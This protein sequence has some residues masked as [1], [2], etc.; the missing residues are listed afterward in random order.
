MLV[1]VPEVWHI[2]NAVLGILQRGLRGLGP[3]CLLL[4][5]QPPSTPHK[6]SP[7][8]SVGGAVCA[9]SVL[10]TEYRGFLSKLGAHFP[11]SAWV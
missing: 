4:L 6:S 3:C 8:S 2:K 10:Q 5:P 9:F 1:G 11:T 7:L